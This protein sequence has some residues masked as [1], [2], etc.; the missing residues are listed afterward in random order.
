VAAHPRVRRDVR[1]DGPRADD[2]PAGVLADAGS[3]LGDPLHVDD[4]RRS[5][6]PVAE[7]DDQVGPAREQAR[8]RAVLLDEVDRIL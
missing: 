6:G 8:A 1:H 2:E 5:R 4:D 3:Q 7:A